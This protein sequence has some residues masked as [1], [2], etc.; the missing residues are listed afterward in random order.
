MLGRPRQ[1]HKSNGRS[2]L[3]TAPTDPGRVPVDT[4]QFVSS[5]VVPGEDMV[6]FLVSKQRPGGPTPASPGPPGKGAPCGPD[7]D[8][9]GSD[10]DLGCDSYTKC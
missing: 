6:S 10:G 4:R 7:T 5:L 1:A 8:A 9:P 3:C 2:A